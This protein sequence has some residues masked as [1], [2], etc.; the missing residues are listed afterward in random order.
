MALRVSIRGAES[1]A[2][3]IGLIR[4]AFANCKGFPDDRG[5]D[6]FASLHGLALPQWCQHGTLLF[7]PWHRAYLYYFELALQTRLGQRFTI[8]NAPTVETWGDVGIPWWDWSSPESQAF[9]IPDSYTDQAADNP[10][11]DSTITTAAGGPGWATGVWSSDLVDFVRSNLRLSG[12]I[13]GDDPPITVRDTDPPPELPSDANVQ[14]CLEQTTFENF[15]QLLENYHG[16]VHIWVGGSMSEVPTAGYDPI[17]WSH[18]AMIDR[19][20]YI[21]QMS[22]RGVSPPSSLLDVVLAPFPMTVRDTL[23]IA[24]LGYDYAVQVAG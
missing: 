7:L 1:D 23:D 4:D 22:S 13:S 3:Q 20:W 14:E 16:D 18:H 2:A 21:W 12:T 24:E 10:L 6:F 15:S 8:L 9:G 19:I 11:A 5:F 17:F